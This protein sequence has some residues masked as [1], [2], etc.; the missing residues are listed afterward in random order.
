MN[1]LA[2]ELKGSKSNIENDQHSAWRHQSCLI[3]LRLS[4]AVTERAKAHWLLLIEN[5]VSSHNTSHYSFSGT[6]EPLK[7]PTVRGELLEC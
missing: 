1:M 7:N 2:S 4:V 5:L 3:W 6:D